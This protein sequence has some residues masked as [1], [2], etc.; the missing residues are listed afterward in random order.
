MKLAGAETTRTETPQENGVTSPLLTQPS[1]PNSPPV[2][3][4]ED[5]YFPLTCSCSVAITSARLQRK[6]NLN[7]FRLTAAGN[8]LFGVYQDWLHQNTG[9][10]L[11]G[12]IGEDGNGQER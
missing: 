8:A 4:P 6:R 3:V 5:L 10:H 7:T 1:P 9:T 12:G 2:D 11:D